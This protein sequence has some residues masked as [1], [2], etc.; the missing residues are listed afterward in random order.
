MTT[1]EYRILD[2]PH[3]ESDG[4]DDVALAPVGRQIACWTTGD[5]Q[6]SPYTEAGSPIVGVAVCDTSTGDVRGGVA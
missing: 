6:G 4:V 5:T 2:R 3:V 1:G